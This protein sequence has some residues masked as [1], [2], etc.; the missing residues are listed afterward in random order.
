MAAAAVHAM[1]RKMGGS[2]ETGSMDA[3]MPTCDTARE[4][5]TKGAPVCDFHRGHLGP[6]NLNTGHVNPNSRSALL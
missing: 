4:R 5:A 3:A 6:P 1:E 2:A